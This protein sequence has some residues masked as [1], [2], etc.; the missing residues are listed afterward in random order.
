[1]FKLRTVFFLTLFSILILFIGSCNQNSNKISSEGKSTEKQKNDLSKVL[2]YYSHSPGDSLKLRAA[3]FLL[4][5]MS[6]HFSKGNANL[7][8]S[9]LTVYT[10]LDSLTKK[11]YY[12]NQRSYPKFGDDKEMEVSPLNQAD[13]HFEKYATGVRRW[14]EGHKFEFS[15][16]RRDDLEHIS[17]DWLIDHI[18]TAFENWSTSKYCRK[19]TFSE[20]V[21]TLLMYRFRNEILSIRSSEIR[22]FINPIV[23]Q[24]SNLSEVIYDIN[25]Y[26]FYMDCFENDGKKV[27]ELAFFDLMQ[28]YMFECGRHSEWMARA[29]N[30][31][32]V[33]ST[34]DFTP[35]WFSRDRPHFWVSA[36]DTSGTYQPFT[37]KWQALGDSTYFQSVSKVFRYV[38][39]P[40]EG[41]YSN[42]LKN[43][44][45]PDVFNTPY[46]KDV[47]EQYHE[48][49]DFSLPL[50]PKLLDRKFV[51]L[52]IFAASGWKPI[53][54][55]KVNP[56]GDSATFEKVPI[57]A[58]YL[59]GFWQND[60]FIP[61]SDPFYIN[62]THQILALK[63]NLKRRI[64]AKLTR[65]FYDKISLLNKMEE[66]AGSTI[67]VASK[68]DWSDVQLLH[69][70]EIKDLTEESVR[71]VN[72]VS[73]KGVSYL[74]LI[75]KPKAMI[76]LGEIEVYGKRKG[77]TQSEQKLKLIP[78]I[79]S[80]N[81]KLLIDGNVETFFYSKTMLF[82]F[83][84]P[85]FI[86]KIK[87]V[88]RTANNGITPG[89]RYELFYYNGRWV[90]AGEQ[91]ARA[92]FLI[93]N[94]LPTSA[95]FWLRNLDRGR[96]EQAFQYSNS[97]QFFINHDKFVKAIR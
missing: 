81:L 46:I 49:V 94:N 74:R 15:E 42:H 69:T 35:S 23:K 6:G 61:I 64:S 91:K 3:N 21:E 87:I 43:E 39:S 7:S 24:S 13:Y 72:A 92:K 66:T 29:L 40:T 12:S 31:V 1:M 76:H 97:Q 78:A 9:V 30:S 26:A 11:T 8:D 51:Y 2:E 65:K 54:W 53:G 25:S 84:Q 63:P 57:D 32:G 18:N 93:Y 83:E 28:F 96:E 19:M 17:S 79:D 71:K 56:T 36:R 86:S 70:I 48:V 75:S 37:P 20:F 5:N 55:G 77:K 90:S 50:T 73:N 44:F 85:V 34:V 82:K 16:K 4:R 10:T 62:K 22:D 80:T 58:T 45:I 41:P 59:A 60:T 95:I 14:L 33:P 38:Y 89:D 52:C 88:P 67:E 27:G 68:S 47:T